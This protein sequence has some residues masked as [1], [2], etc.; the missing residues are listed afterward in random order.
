LIDIPEIVLAD[1]DQKEL[2]ILIHLIGTYYFGKT[3]LKSIPH[4]LHIFNSGSAVLDYFAGEKNVNII[5]LD[6]VM[7]GISGV[8]TAKYLRDKGFDGY[9]VFL[10]SVNDFAAES[11]KVRA[12][13]Y[14]LK[15]VKKE[16]LF[17]VIQKIEDART[18]SYEE[19]TAA[20]L[21]QSKQY[22]RNVLFRE[23]V[24]VEIMGH[25]LYIQLTNNEKISLNK[26]LHEI[27]PALL[28]DDRFAHCHGS[29]IANM[30]FVETIKDNAAVLRTGQSIPISRRC[31]DF[32]TRYI[33]RSMRRG[34]SANEPSVQGLGTG[35]RRFGR[36]E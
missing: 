3:Q 5:F 26:P 28:A 25:K 7:P 35:L 16:Q 1:D 31:N 36:E 14:L 22:Y 8:E 20:I 30:D 4:N 2:D 9:I 10:T 15:P 18:K 27:S 12:F 24:Y 6:I 17:N 33:T 11:Y 29:I 34:T 21:I 32:K 13:S 19:D 23:I